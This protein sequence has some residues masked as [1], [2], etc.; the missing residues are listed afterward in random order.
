MAG[1]TR[2]G[3]SKSRL[4]Y[5]KKCFVFA[6]NT[7]Y[8]RIQVFPLASAKRPLKAISIWWGANDA[9]LPMRSQSIPL[10][11]FKDNIERM[12]DMLQSKDSPHY[13]GSQTSIIL[14]SCPPICVSQ[15]KEDVAARLGPGIELDRSAERTKQFAEAMGQVAEKRKVGF[16]NVHDAMMQAAGP[17]PEQGLRK[18]LSDGLH[19]TAQG[20]QVRSFALSR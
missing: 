4:T 1:I 18:L 6:E 16:V 11:Q 3:D 10:Q 2:C 9:T 12:I 20:Y 8:E 7:E 14:F 5:V 15:R 17:D 13:S 19:L